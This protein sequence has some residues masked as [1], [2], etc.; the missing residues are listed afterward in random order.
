[1]TAKP[2]VFLRALDGGDLERTYR[3]HNDPELYHTLVDG[4]RFV[5]N[6]VESDWLAKRVS[7]SQSE[8]NLAI[9]LTP[10][11]KHIGNV[12]LRPINLIFRNAVLGIF[13]GGKKLSRPRVWPP[14]TMRSPP[15][16]IR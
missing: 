4:F 9:C 10:G 13:I 11:R 8:V 16:R 2:K 7:Y 3:W 12:Y 14:S 6:D 1:M 15:A 5:S